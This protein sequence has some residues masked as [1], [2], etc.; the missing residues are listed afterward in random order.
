MKAV[1]VFPG[2]REVKVVDKELPRLVEPDE[3]M[4]RLLDV[5]ICGT[6]KEICS[7]EYGTPPAGEDHLVIGH[8]ALA[9]VVEI[10]SAVS[11]L[12][13]GDLVVPTVRRPCPHPGCLSCRSRH[14]GLLLHRGLHRARRQRGPRLHDR[15]RG[16]P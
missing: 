5:G 9:E 10:G 1:A 3:V 7:F 2:A 11:G 8:E 16:G 13:P 4:L 14:Q 6:D 15:V 12:R